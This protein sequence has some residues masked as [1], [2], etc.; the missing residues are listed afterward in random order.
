MIP[1][2]PRREQ[3]FSAV[4]V[5]ITLL[6]VL[7]SAALAVDVSGFYETARTDQTTADLACLAGVPHLPGAGAT[8]RSAAAE[9]VQRNFPSLA[10][11]TATTSGSILT[12]S[13]GA[14]NTAVI[15]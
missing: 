6:F 4:W 11:V 5:A 14:G 2:R 7:A 8:A 1:T 9:N 3:G 13:D 15:T 12:L 10:A